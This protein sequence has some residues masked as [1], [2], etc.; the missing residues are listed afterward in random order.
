M[1]TYC[2]KVNGFDTLKYSSLYLLDSCVAHFV[3]AAPMKP[4][5]A[6]TLYY[7]ILADELINR[8]HK[9]TFLTTHHDLEATK[10]EAV[11]LSWPSKTVTEW[12]DAVFLY[13]FARR[14][15]PDC[16]ISQFSTVNICMLVG[17]LTGISTRIAWYRTLF[18]QVRA[19]AKRADWIE[20]LKLLR[21]RFVYLFA[22]HIIANSRAAAED[23]RAVYNLSADKLSVLHNLVSPPE[24]EHVPTL[25][26][27]LVSVGRFTP[28]K[29]QQVLVEALPL[30]CKHVPDV[31]AD[32]YGAGAQKTVCEARAA[33]LGVADLCT[34]H[35]HVPL[36]KVMQALAGASVCVVTSQNEAFGYV[37]AEAQA[38]G[39]PVVASKVDGLLDV[40][41]EGK[42]GFLVPPEDPAAF[43]DKIT[44]LLLD[45]SLREQ[46]G[47]NA[48]EHFLTNFSVSN[49]GQHADHLEQLVRAKLTGGAGLATDS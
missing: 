39:T 37:A 27:R 22:T 8:G 30:V 34:F 43:A 18:T 20:D 13:T 17:A 23:A 46:F 24:V 15:R 29:N 5:K 1:P 2:V 47:V 9:A 32:F 12:R 7:S 19:D 4:K 31:H 21:K 25:P 35:G 28:S 14:E 48:R 45:E 40:V 16:I 26:N 44:T 10:S 49:I 3:I 11:F 42:T 6:N 38:V 41:Q 33:D 36:P